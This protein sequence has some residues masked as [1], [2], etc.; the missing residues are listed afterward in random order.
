MDKKKAKRLLKFLSYVLC[1]SPDEFGIFLDND[2]SLSTKELLWAIKEEEGWSY[3]R[4]SHL[5]DLILLG[6]DPPYHIEGKKIVLNDEI[7]KPYYPVEEPPRILYHAARLK[8]CYH[9]YR[10]GL[11]AAGRPYLPLAITKELALRIGKRRD[12]SPLLLEISA[13]EAFLEGI[14]FRC[15]GTHMFLAEEIPPRFISGPPLPEREVKKTRERKIKKAKE[16]EPVREPLP[17]SFFLDLERD[18][19]PFRRKEKEKR[20]KKGPAWKREV[21]KI[22]KK[23]RGF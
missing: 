15:H 8:A 17:G 13:Q 14:I 16:S 18:L 4:E 5:R 6:L 2:G 10:H 12:K 22:R 1:H 23:K 9:I 3:V 11:K 20:R 21:R 19:D 7:P